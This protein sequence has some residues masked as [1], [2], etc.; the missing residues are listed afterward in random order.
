MTANFTNAILCASYQRSESCRRV[1]WV[2][3]A[4]IVR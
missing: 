4:F 2:C 3:C 1:R